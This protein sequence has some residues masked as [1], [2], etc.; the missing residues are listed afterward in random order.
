M[1]HSSRDSRTQTN[2]QFRATLSPP[3]HNHRK[4][5]PARL[6]AAKGEPQGKE[7]TVRA[8]GGTLRSSSGWGAIYRPPPSR[9]TIKDR[10]PHRTRIQGSSRSSREG[11]RGQDKN[12]RPSQNA[13]LPPAGP[14]QE[15]QSTAGPSRRLSKHPRIRRAAA[16]S[17][18]PS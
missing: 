8:P 15:K 1:D 13:R 2:V 11:P 9:A 5:A 4:Q 6:I 3:E 12:N 14:E 18:H 10:R 17:K 16:A 7:K